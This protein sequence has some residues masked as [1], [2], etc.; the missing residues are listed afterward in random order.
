MYTHT[1]LKKRVK[2]CVEQMKA[3]ENNN[4][5]LRMIMAKKTFVESEMLPNVNDM[6]AES[7]LVYLKMSV[8]PWVFPKFV[9]HEVERET[10]GDLFASSVRPL[11]KAFRITN[12]TLEDEALS[13]VQAATFLALDR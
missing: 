10:K 13:P 2:S 3:T 9:Q 12:E 8:L 5:I 11:H 6:T 7:I 1:H 4:L